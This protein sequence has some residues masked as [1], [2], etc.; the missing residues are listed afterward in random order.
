MTGV[1]DKSD[2]NKQAIKTDPDGQTR[3]IK[4]RNRP[5]LVCFPC[6][7]KKIKCDKGKPCSTCVK[8]DIVNECTY[9]ER[10][11]NKQNG[12][13]KVDEP[14]SKKRK[15][16]SSEL[17][18]K[19][20]KEII[21]SSKDVCVLIRKSELE[22]LQASLKHYELQASSKVTKSNS[23]TIETD[24]D[25]DDDV[26]YNKS[27]N[28]YRNVIFSYHDES[29]PG[30]IP[31]EN[32]TKDKSSSKLS[33]KLSVTSKIHIS[34]LSKKDKFLIGINPYNSSDDTI[35]FYTILY[36]N[37]NQFQ[38]TNFYPMS[39][40]S[41]IRNS[42][43]LIA[44]RKFA[45]SQKEDKSIK[46][47]ITYDPLKKLMLPKD[48]SVKHALY[49]DDALHEKFEEKDE[50]EQEQLKKKRKVNFTTFALGLSMLTGPKER[51]SD[52]IEQIK[53]VM[54]VQ[55]CVWLLIRRYLTLLYPL[56]PFLIEQQFINKIERIIGKENYAEEKPVLKIENQ[57]DFAYISILFVI[58][59]LSYLSLFHN[60][61]FY[62]EKILTGTNL[63][64]D[65]QEK[66]Y[67]LINPIN[68]YTIEIAQACLLHL[69]KRGKISFPILQA[70]V[71]LRLYKVYGPEEGDGLDGGNSQLHIS[72]IISMA[73]MLGLNKDPDT[74]NVLQDEREKTLYRKMWYYCLIM[75]Y[76][77]SYIYGNPCL[78]KPDSYDTKRP[79][80]TPE[81]SNLIDKEAD[82]AS[83]ALFAFGSALIN[84]PINNL[85]GLYEKVGQSIKLMD[86]T[87]HL[88]HLEQGATKLVGKMEDYIYRLEEE[89]RSYHTN[90][91]MKIG[92]LLRMDILMISN[93]CYL[94]NYYES[95]NP[96]LSFFY[97]KK[98]LALTMNGM[99]PFIFPLISRSQE[100]FGE[101]ADLY[102]NPSLMLSL[103]R[104]SDIALIA[105][106]R[107]N[108]SL[109]KM[110]NNPNHKT[111]LKDENYKKL[112]NS[113]NKFIMEM[114]KCCRIC[115]TATSLLSSRYYFAWGI[116]KSQ[117]Y[118]LKLIH[119]PTFY[120]QYAT[121]D[122][123]FKRPNCEQ[124]TEVTDIITNGL[125][126]LQ[127]LVSKYCTDVDILSL[128]RKG[129]NDHSSSSNVPITTSQ[130]MVTPPNL[131]ND[132]TFNSSTSSIHNHTP[133]NGLY[134]TGFEDLQFDNSAEI[135][136]IWL[137]MLNS[138][139]DNQ[140]NSQGLIDNFQEQQQLDSILGYPLP[141][142][143]YET[144][145][146]ENA[147]NQNDFTNKPKSFNENMFDDLRF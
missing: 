79:Y 30:F 118:Y 94:F 10:L 9:D 34:E 25:Q 138:K 18:K 32:V 106:S 13:E 53:S 120:K 37:S 117:N 74:T 97:L 41:I 111:K 31:V 45:E 95:K 105:M 35:S 133:L 96:K 4:K 109:Y 58:L 22:Q 134:F 101:G 107:S 6:R 51:E 139:I 38:N 135:D 54:P 84:G 116:V 143:F 44:L 48:E 63:T 69:E 80:F 89:D 93:Y 1:N 14:E 70:S 83:Y 92:I 114:E 26:V 52:L 7:K 17:T 39:W 55:K 60:R 112:F 145:N 119:N 59:R 136:S 28:S 21:D 108:F 90:K 91:I 36:Q 125:E 75:E 50:Q 110:S 43:S 81:N 64:V 77:Q 23:N 76:N 122:L 146:L 68:I 128:F 47:G 140:G 42:S 130:S 142:Q 24:S 104:I 5:S 15:K 103:S 56:M 62:N 144:I 115:L 27:V 33:E 123:H 100:L 73:Y 99:L 11:T 127:T 78:I 85:L 131:S 141:N 124:V 12:N 82:K 137:Q 98:L 87:N 57:I 102:I 46:V 126:K 67:L 2:F 65:E 113:L 20:S 88:N 71:Y 66:K 19:E 72:Q 86:L 61:G 129:E 49:L 8:N 132:L 29:R 121:N 16:Q 147:H 3:I 40:N